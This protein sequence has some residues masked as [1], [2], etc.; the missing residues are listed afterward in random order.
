MPSDRTR[1][2]VYKTCEIPS[3]HKKT[4]FHC[5][6]GP[7]VDRELVHLS[8]VKTVKIQLHVVLATYFSCRYPCISTRVE[9][10]E[11]KRF[12]PN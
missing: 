1:R 3:E 4:L 10:D 2:N 9:L 5:E 8:S 12:L 6:G 7:K 11:H